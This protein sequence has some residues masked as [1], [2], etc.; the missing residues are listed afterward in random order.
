MEQA[1]ELFGQFLTTIRPD[2]I[3]DIMIYAV[4]FLTLLTSVMIPDGNDRATNLSYGVMVLCVADL[5]VLQQAFRS[6]G[7]SE[8]ALLGYVAHVGMF[9]LPAIT[10]GSIRVREKKGR[11]SIPLAAVTAL[12]GLIYLVASFANPGQIYATT[13]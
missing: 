1:Q 11:A 13:F 2:S 5:L 8:M 9:I 6:G 10:A 3:G 4:F 12:V 7:N